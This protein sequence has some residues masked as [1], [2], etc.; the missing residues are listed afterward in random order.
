MNC[1]D[2]FRFGDLPT[3]L[4]F[5]VLEFTDLVAPTNE[6]S[7]DPVKGYKVPARGRRADASWQP[8]RAIF[9]VSK[10]FSAEAR[11]VFFRHN[12]IVVWPDSSTFTGSPGAHAGEYAAT[13]FLSRH[14]SSTDGTT[15]AAAAISATSLRDQHLQPRHLE[16]PA[17]TTIG[18]T[19][20]KTGEQASRNWL[21]T[22]RCAHESGALDSLRFLRITGSWSDAPDLFNSL[23]Y[24]TDLSRLRSF[25]QERIWPFVDPEQGAPWLP[26]EL[27][28]MM[29]DRSNSQTRYSIRRRGYHDRDERAD[30]QPSGGVS[31]S[32]FI[33]WKP[34][35]Q[36]HVK[37][38]WVPGARDSEWV[39]EVWLKAGPAMGKPIC[40][41]NVQAEGDRTIDAI[42][43]IYGLQQQPQPILVV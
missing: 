22:L 29:Q 1:T 21:R 23:L 4:R 7:W 11:E 18:Q 31:V 37:G 42:D 14:V 3:E 9:R 39:E 6:I 41:P 13:A 38:R 43:T 5:N 12:R 33:S 15:T 16:F 10:G 34:P 17:L 28:V 2:V 32:R 19:D 40:V 27:E 20:R 25:V 8:P 35:S 24:A 36:G 26:R 30:A